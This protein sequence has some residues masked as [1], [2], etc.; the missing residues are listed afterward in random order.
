MSKKKIVALALAVAMLAVVI[1]GASL[2]YFSDKTVVAKNTFT[3]GKV[4]IKLEE[5]V[6]D[7]NG[8]KTD[9]VT[10]TGNNDI[11]DDFGYFLVPGKTVDKDPFVTVIKGS[12][13]CYVR[14]KV[15]LNNADKFLEIY[16]TVD[17]LNL[18]E[19]LKFFSYTP[20]AQ[21]GATT[22]P[23]PVEGYNTTDW[24]AVN[25]DMSAYN[26]NEKTITVIFNYKNIVE[27]NADED[28]VLPYL[29]TSVKLPEWV[30]NAQAALFT[31]GFEVDIVAEA[32]QAEGFEATNDKTA[33]QVA[34]EAFDDATVPFGVGAPTNP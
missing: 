27:K 23:E 2:A 32:I 3:V 28:T 10:E 8:K 24:E 14:L 13:D 4:D 15:T 12:E 17:G 30:T 5:H 20:A 29:V 34:W 22:E 9:D 33:M 26:E 19:A 6:V 11:V 16:R 18:A 25:L 31:E 21:E 7:E 1:V